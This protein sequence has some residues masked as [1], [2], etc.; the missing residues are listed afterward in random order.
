MSIF[1]EANLGLYVKSLVSYQQ[2]YGKVARRHT[3]SY[4]AVRLVLIALLNY[5]QDST[6]F[7]VRSASVR[8]KLTILEYIIQPKLIRP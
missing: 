5:G 6:Q 1:S 3:L 4:V 2:I 8:S 7:D